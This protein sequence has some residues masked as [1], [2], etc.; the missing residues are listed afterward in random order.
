MVELGLNIEDAIKINRDEVY[1]ACTTTENEGQILISPY[2]LIPPSF[3]VRVHNNP[4]KALATTAMISSFAC[5]Y[6]NMRVFIDPD[7][8]LPRAHATEAHFLIHA[9]KVISEYK[10]QGYYKNII[11]KYPQGI[12]SLDKKC[13]TLICL[14]LQI[15]ET[16]NQHTTLDISD[17]QTPHLILQKL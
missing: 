5:N 9:S 13:F 7:N 3:L 12:K 2:I 14:L 15:I 4:I 16:T 17:P 11:E 10:P 8:I 6:L 1:C